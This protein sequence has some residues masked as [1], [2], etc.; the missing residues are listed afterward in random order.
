MRNT[1]LLNYWLKSTPEF[2]F[3]KNS[4]GQYINTSQSNAELAGF[5]S[6]K[7]MIGKYDYEIYPPEI[8]QQFLIQDK[9][10]YET[11]KPLYDILWVNHPKLGRI[12]IK[13]FK[14]PMLDDANNVIGLY[15]I[16]VNI[17]DKFR[18]KEN[19]KKQKAKTQT[20]LDNIPAA[21]WI[22]NNN[23]KYI[24][25][26]YAFEK[27]YK[28]SRADIIGQNNNIE[29]LNKIFSVNDIELIRLQDMEVMREK[30]TKSLTLLTNEG[31][32]SRLVLIKKSPLIK[33]DGSC[34]G[35]I[36][37][38]NELKTQGTIDMLYGKN[39]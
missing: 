24:T 12:Q 1:D 7:E 38:S 2:V 21:V 6:S 19:I 16:S 29:L 27:F 26:N 22:K 32:K 20:I 10:I 33:G 5:S 36:G 30:R 13:C 25:I 17:T 31:K 11:K 37:M 15:G 3:F 39:I 8:A 14:A 35:L 4:E 18:M 28:V 23:N 34:V 9:K